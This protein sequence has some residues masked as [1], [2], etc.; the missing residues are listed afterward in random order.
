MDHSVLIQN[1]ETMTY[2]MEGFFL[3]MNSR[4]LL[5]AV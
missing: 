5:N 1:E 2:K 3:S 4:F